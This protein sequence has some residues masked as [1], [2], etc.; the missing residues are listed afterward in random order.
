VADSYQDRIVAAE[1]QL[2]IARKA[3][4]LLYPGGR[5]WEDAQAKVEE[6]E[7]TLRELRRQAT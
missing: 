6:W 7:A 4:D 1:N 2:H 3:R 5:E